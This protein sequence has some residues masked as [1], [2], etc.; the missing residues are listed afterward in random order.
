M[1]FNINNCIGNCINYIFFIDFKAFLTE[2]R[3]ITSSIILLTK[4]CERSMLDAIL[5]AADFI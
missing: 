3:S 1:I 5:L 4:L 2:D